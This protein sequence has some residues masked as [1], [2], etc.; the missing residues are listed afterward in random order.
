[1]KILAHK[2]NEYKSFDDL[3]CSEVEGRDYKIHLRETV[4]EIVVIALHGG[5]IEPGTQEIAADVA[6]KDYSFYAF[7]GKKF[8]G[9]R[10]LHIKS[11]NYDEPQCLKLVRGSKTVLSIHGC[12][13]VSA[14]VYLGGLDEHLKS[15]IKEQLEKA[16]FKVKSSYKKILQG[17]SPGNI[18]N[19]G[20][21]GKGVQ[22]E[23]SNALRR[24]MF[25][26]L[27]HIG[28]KKKTL[29]FH[30]FVSALREALSG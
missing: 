5:N 19:K 22:L 14:V 6:G 20:Q 15:V 27:K 1:L 9:N 17:K 8:K 16:G 28:R 2:K 25:A 7:E 29:K 10:A 3:Q 4:S 24:N 26:N 12:R 21:T 23:L 30:N 11:V 13:G 18:C